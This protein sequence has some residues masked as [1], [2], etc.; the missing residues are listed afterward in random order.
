MNYGRRII[1]TDATEITAANVADEVRKA[2]MVHESN[3]ADAEKLNGYFCG[4]TEILNKKKEI[5][6]EI[7]HKINVN[8]A[9]EIVDF[10]LGYCFGEPIQYIRRGDEENLTNDIATLNNFMYL[11][12]KSTAD[13]ELAEWM[14]IAGVGYIIVTRYRSPK[15]GRDDVTT[16]GLDKYKKFR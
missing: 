7:N 4:K 13:K 2:V 12:D 14:L 8:R 6:E 5:R 3:R 16:F 10:K 1:Y 15:L 11:A 9:K